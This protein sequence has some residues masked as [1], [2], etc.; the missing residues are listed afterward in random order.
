MAIFVVMFGLSYKDLKVA[1]FGLGSTITPC[2]TDCP[3]TFACES[4]LDMTAKKLTFKNPMYGPR[5]DVLL[6]WG[7]KFSPCMRTDVAVYASLAADRQRECGVLASNT[8]EISDQD[9]YSCCTLAN[10]RSGLSS[11]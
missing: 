6:Q 3:L 9:G 2:T 8:C 1:P 7:A 4:C 10:F 11:E 5:L